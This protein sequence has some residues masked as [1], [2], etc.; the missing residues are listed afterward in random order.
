MYQISSRKQKYQ[1]TPAIYPQLDKKFSSDCFDENSQTNDKF[2]QTKSVL[3]KSAAKRNAH[4][5]R[6]AL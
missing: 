3:N 6:D 1:Q 4:V 2:S 5:V